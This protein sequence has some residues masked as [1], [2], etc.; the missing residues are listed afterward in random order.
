MITTGNPT[1]KEKFSRLQTFK[2]SH[3]N[4][5]EV[6]Q[7]HAIRN[8]NWIT[9][10]TGNM[11]DIFRH[12]Q[13]LLGDIGYQDFIPET[14]PEFDAFFKAYW[15]ARKNETDQCPYQILGETYTQEYTYWQIY[16]IMHDK[17]TFRMA[18]DD[19]KI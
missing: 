18:R 1:S 12:M 15:D 10:D 8:R 9:I 4:V 6:C 3:L 17:F 16:Q 14:K 5:F 11:A 2:Y 7:A 13:N 19:R